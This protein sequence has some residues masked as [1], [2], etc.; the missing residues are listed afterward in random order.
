MS[1]VPQIL[2]LQGGGSAYLGRVWL[3]LLCWVHTILK[4]C[5]FREDLLS[6]AD[7]RDFCAW[8]SICIFL[9]VGVA[10][11]PCA[12]CVSLF[13][14]KAGFC[15]KS[16]LSCC[17]AVTRQCSFPRDKPVSSSKSAVHV[18]DGGDIETDQAHCP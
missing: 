10:S 3:C 13:F 14:L 15:C 12:T 18:C 11:F 16:F 4:V 1:L 7:L 2:G 9:L 6:E 17:V 5:C 8:E